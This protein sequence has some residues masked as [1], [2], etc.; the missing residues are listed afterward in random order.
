[1]P[2]S[3]FT[4]ISIFDLKG[5]KVNTILNQ[6]ISAGFHSVIWDARNDLGKK[7]SAGVYIYTIQ[8][9]EFRQ[10]RKMVLLK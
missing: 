3:S 5:N 8:A 7:V 9:G 2:Q 1:L 6:Q 10:V 4:S